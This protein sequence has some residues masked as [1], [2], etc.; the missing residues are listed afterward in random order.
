MPVTVRRIILPVLASFIAWTVCGA[1]HLLAQPAPRLATLTID[2]WPEYDR[3]STVLVIYRGELAADVALPAPIKIRIP[4]SAGGPFAVASPAPGAETTAVKQWLD[5]TAAR[6]ITA[7]RSGE[8]IEVA[9]TPPSRLF[10]LEFYD[11]LD[12]TKP[13]RSYSIIWP[14]DLAIEAMAVNVREPVGARD[15][16][17]NPPL[18]PGVLDEEGLIA[19]QS[20]LPGPAA[21]QPFTLTLSYNRQETRTSAEL[22]QLIT[23]APTRPPTFSGLTLQA[24]WPL[25]AVLVIVLVL[26]AGG[27]LWLTRPRPKSFRPYEPPTLRHLRGRRS[28]RPRPVRRPPPRPIIEALSEDAEAS[29]CTQCGKPL[30]PDDIFCSRCGTRVKGK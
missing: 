17:T 24:W 26:V 21:G 16:V 11:T 29:F 20:A 18:S 3:P 28:A 7:T 15:M 10:L 14:G 30:Q 1:G 2:V 23:P 12:T 6:Q 22:L 25:V 19:H 4:A 27:A 9:F 13:E 5:L 8:W